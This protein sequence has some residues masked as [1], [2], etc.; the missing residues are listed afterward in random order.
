MWVVPRQ[1]CL[2]FGANIKEL[3]LLKKKNIL[4]DH[5]IYQSIRIENSKQY[6]L[7]IENVQQNK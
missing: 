6:T 1:L 4:V 3:G 7:K 5:E 2:K